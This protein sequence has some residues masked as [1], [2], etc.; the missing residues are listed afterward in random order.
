MKRLFKFSLASLALSLCIGCG[1]LVAREQK[2]LAKVEAAA[3]TVTMH[4]PT[5]S[6]Q[7]NP[8]VK[9][10]ELSGGDINTNLELSI[11]TF[12]NV[13]PACLD[14]STVGGHATT[15]WT[16]TTAATNKARMIAVPVRLALN[17]PAQS[18][19][20]MNS[21]NYSLGANS[22]NAKIEL[23]EDSVFSGSTGVKV[24]V[25]KKSS[26]ALNY[27]Y[28]SGSNAFNYSRSIR[29]YNQTGSAATKTLDYFWLVLTMPKAVNNAQYTFQFK[30]NSQNV[31]DAEE[32]VFQV[33]S[34]TYSLSE[35][36]SS[37]SSF[38]E[39]A[40]A[41]VIKDFTIDSSITFSKSITINLNNH[42]VTC[43]AN[44][45]IT[46]TSSVTITSSPA[47]GKLTTSQ[48]ILVNVQGGT[49]TV[50]GS[51]QTLENTST[52]SGKYVISLTQNNGFVTLEG[53]T[54]IKGGQHGIYAGMQG[55]LAVG[56]TTTFQG[57]SGYGIYSIAGTPIYLYQQ[58]N[59]GKIYMPNITGSTLILENRGGTLSY[60]NTTNNLEIYFPS[61]LSSQKT[62][63]NNVYNQSVANHVFFK[64]LG[65]GYMQQYI[66]SGH[67]IECTYFATAP[68]FV[69]THC[70][71][72][73]P[74]VVLN[75]NTGAAI[76][77][78]ADRGYDLPANIS[79]TNINSNL[80]SWYQNAGL[81]NIQSNAVTQE[82]TITVTA[83]INTEGKALEF[84]ANNMHMTDYDPS[85][86][87]SGSGYC[88]DNTHHY[89]STAKSAFN[90]LE[91]TTRVYIMENGQ[92]DIVAAKERLVAWAAANGDVIV[93]D[94]N[95]YVINKAS[96]FIT[97][98]NNV[99]D[100]NTAL[101]VIVIAFT[102]VTMF[103]VLIT[104][105]K[106]RFSK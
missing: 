17:V 37:K 34:D 99:E 75:Y 9:Y 15:T 36:I 59:V 6:S 81:L 60:I 64:S 69:L 95:D 80:Y 28:G 23:F 84:I 53:A 19:A 65:T 92:A 86:S 71:I 83:T 31:S 68:T 13:S 82:V 48:N 94:S 41:A 52:A 51:G 63:A 72:N 1:V 29:F 85:L 14:G 49:L 8:K 33:G 10:Y 103:A 98:F 27:Y 76:N 24:D 87:G 56:G 89:Y 43:T 57:Q 32:V 50:G 7:D 77:F 61:A 44:N 20:Y 88:K 26:T 2:G 70:S 38:A 101:Y 97:P 66:E 16:I 96:R 21:F 74:D 11:S 67:Y 35:F 42:I 105:K 18:A 47:G 79:V 30:I 12:S 55:N 106:K 40:V 25:T 5:Q 73:E 46:V 62:I 102:S 39:G 54:T 58:A 22:A 45:A 4:L 104:L 90:S 3:G 78:T 91:K 100:N 93:S